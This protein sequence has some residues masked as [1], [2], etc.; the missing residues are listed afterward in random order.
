VSGEPKIKRIVTGVCIY[1]ASFPVFYSESFTIEAY[2][3]MCIYRWHFV[4]KEFP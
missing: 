1:G 2:V 3:R 4:N